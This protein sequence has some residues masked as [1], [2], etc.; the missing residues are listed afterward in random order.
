MSERMSTFDFDSCN[1]QATV[2]ENLICNFE[3]HIRQE[4][5]ATY[6]SH[7]RHF[8]K[9]KSAKIALSAIWNIGRTLI[10]T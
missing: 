4:L 3:W 7:Y 10:G 6:S 5:N 2:W 8:S 1:A 9:V